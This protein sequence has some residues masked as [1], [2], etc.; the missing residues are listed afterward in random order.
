[1]GFSSMN[2]FFTRPRIIAAVVLLLLALALALGPPILRLLGLGLAG[3]WFAW[4]R[5]RSLGVWLSRNHRDLLCGSA[6]LALTF[7]M[8]LPF[9]TG[10]RPVSYDHTIHYAKAWQLWQ[11]L[12]QGRLWGWADH[13]L[14]GYPVGFNYPLG[15]DIWVNLVYLALLGFCDL[16]QAYGVALFLLYFLMALSIYLLGARCLNRGVGLL[17]A[18]LLVLE[19]GAITIGG[20]TWIVQWGVW[21]CAL[22]VALSLLALSRFERLRVPGPDAN[23]AMVSLALLVCAAVLCHPL[24]LIHLGLMVPLCMV[25]YLLGAPP[26]AALGACLRLGGA[27]LV[28]LG[29]AAWWLV[30]FV[31]AG[32]DQ[33]R[34]SL[35][36]QSWEQMGRNLARGQVIPQ[37]WIYVTALGA[38]GSLALVVTNRFRALII[39]VPTFLLLTLGASSFYHFAGLRQISES[40][41]LIHYPRFAMLV[42]PY[43]CLGAAYVIH[44]A[45][46]GAWRR[47]SPT[48]GDGAKGFS[49]KGLGWRRPLRLALALCLTLPVLVPAGRAMVS[50]RMLRQTETESTRADGLSR[51]ALAAWMEQRRQQDPRFFRFALERS[52]GNLHHHAD[53]VTMTSVPMYKEGHTPAVQFRNRS[54]LLNEGTM[55]A[56]NIRY[57][58]SANPQVNRTTL[59]EVAMVGRWHVFEY[60]GWSAKIFSVERQAAVRVASHTD[61][62]IVLRVEQA[63]G[64]LRLNVADF[65]RWRAYRDGQPITIQPVRPT[66]VQILLIAVDAST[67][68]TYTFR[69]EAAAEE[70]LG[71]LLS[72]LGILLVAGMLVWWKYRTGNGE[73]GTGIKNRE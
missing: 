40:F 54:E 3:G 10:D 2:R 46:A 39:G 71:A 20:W 33:V 45:F 44:A 38:L 35:L 31:S 25:L 43:L 17:A 42:Q 55:R 70:Y 7:V 68:G 60:S 69:F 8:M 24:Q 6:L 52:L 66:G 21:P 36:W 30:P 27:A 51:A 59:R 32:Q 49:L 1:M 72:L 41:A 16:S 37:L 9:S 63:A 14:G 67:P 29:L 26:R 61:N 18:L 4:P 23:R 50:K 15:G 11:Q 47:W 28:G 62:E 5:R 64:R 22:S 48:S 57:L 13:W 12:A 56:L 58:V 53:L 19:Q 65:S 73:R 34:E